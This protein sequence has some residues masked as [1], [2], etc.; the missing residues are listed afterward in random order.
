MATV[1]NVA[2]VVRTGRVSQAGSAVVC[3]VFSFLG[4]YI[5]EKET[6][7]LETSEGC[8]PRIHAIL[9]KQDII[10]AF[11]SSRNICSSLL[12]SPVLVDPENYLIAVCA[13]KCT[14]P[15]YTPP[16]TCTCT[17]ARLVFCFLF[18]GRAPL[19]G[20]RKVSLGS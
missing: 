7:T 1:E 3:D 5:S 17:S 2:T 14:L 19:L 10:E 13:L 6:S 15:S 12:L 20:L 16:P 4:P 11:F 9:Q 8:M 18:F